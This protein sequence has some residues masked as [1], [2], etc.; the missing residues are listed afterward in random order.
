MGELHL[1]NK[2]KIITLLIS[3][4]ILSLIV[5][6]TYFFVYGFEISPNSLYVEKVNVVNGVITIT[7][8]D[9]RD[10]ALAFSG[11]SANLNGEEL[12][13]KPRFSL[14]SQFNRYGNFNIIYDAK[15]ESIKKIIIIGKNEKKNIW[16]ENR[17]YTRY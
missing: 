17:G 11:Y 6:Y 12:F 4:I 9:M 5:L 15:G 8:Y 16:V 7:G 10:S 13:I 2:Y 1:K 14:V 3:S